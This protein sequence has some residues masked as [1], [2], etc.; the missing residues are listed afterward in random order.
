MNVSLPLAQ[1]GYSNQQ[2]WIH[3]VLQP[4]RIFFCSQLIP[5]S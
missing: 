1:Y 5:L 3:F 2:I 4:H